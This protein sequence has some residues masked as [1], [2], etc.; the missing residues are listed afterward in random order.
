MIN[1]PRVP[2]GRGG[3]FVRNNYELSITNYEEGAEN[4]KKPFSVPLFPFTVAFVGGGV[5][6]ENGIFF[7][8]LWE[9]T[10]HLNNNENNE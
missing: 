4:G 1:I 5:F 10:V 3:F 6:V 2:E 9:I 7:I 8:Y